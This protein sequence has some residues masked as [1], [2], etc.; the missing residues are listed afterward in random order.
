MMPSQRLISPKVIASLI[1][2]QEEVYRQQLPKLPGDEIQSA[3][4]RADDLELILLRLL[5]HTR[6]E[7]A[8]IL[9][10]TP[11]QYDSAFRRVRQQLKKE[12]SNIDDFVR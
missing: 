9:G 10:L 1:D 7:I 4:V 3:Q 6:P 2:R 12:F 11:G 5:G 8:T